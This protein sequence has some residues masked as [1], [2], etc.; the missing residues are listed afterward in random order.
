MLSSPGAH[1]PVADGAL[2]AMH[3]S[4]VALLVLLPAF[5]FFAQSIHAG[6]AVYFPTLFPTHLRS[7]G[8]GFCFNTGRILASPVLF[9]LSPWMKST[10]DLRTAITCLGG[11]F[12]FGVVILKFLPETQGEDLPE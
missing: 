9:W 8:A 7:T 11:F 6:Y 1:A 3:S 10:W 5:A 2:P 4:Y 12:L